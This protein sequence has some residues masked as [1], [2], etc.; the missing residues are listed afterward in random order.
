MRATLVLDDG[1]IK[2]LLSAA[3]IKNKT[4]AISI[5]IR[6]YIAQKRREKLLSLGGT[7]KLSSEWQ[8]LRELEKDE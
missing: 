1:M 8:K 4:K 7:M 6:S 2:E 3:G 5:S